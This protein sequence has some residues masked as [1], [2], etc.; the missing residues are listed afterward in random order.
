[1]YVPSEQYQPE[2]A[3][4]IKEITAVANALDLAVNELLLD[5]FEEDHEK[6]QLLSECASD[7]YSL[8]RV[9]P[10]HQDSTK[11]AQQLLKT[12][13]LAVLGNHEADAV[14][15]LEQVAWPKLPLDSDDWRE[16]TWSAITDSWL[17]LIRKDPVDPDTVLQRISDLRSKQEQYEKTYLDNAG[18]SGKSAALEL[19][20]LYHLAK[21]AEIMAHFFK[22]I[23]VE[24]CTRISRLLKK[25]F[26]NAWDVCKHAMLLDLETL[27]LPLDAAAAKL[28]NIASQSVM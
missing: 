20:G 11:A 18:S 6:Q 24:D 28:L 1:M 16:R 26:D 23:D 21:A 15:M 17:R 25:H 8:F 19:I 4:D 2:N 14:S 5:K 9:L 3:N 13:L 22:D 10:L 27:T 7:A 12:S